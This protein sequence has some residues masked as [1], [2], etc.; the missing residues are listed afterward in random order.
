ML[1]AERTI[2]V[3]FKSVRTV[4]LVLCC[5]IVSS[6]S[7]YHKPEYFTS[8]ISQIQGP[9]SA[10]SPHLPVQPGWKQTA[11]APASGGKSPPPAPAPRGRSTA[12]AGQ[13]LRYASNYQ[14]SQVQTVFQAQCEI[15]K[16]LAEKSNCVIVGRC[17]DYA[18]RHNPDLKSIFIYAPIEKR[19]E[20]IMKRFDLTEDKAKSQI[21]KEDKEYF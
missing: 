5:I 18:L 17:A 2:L 9:S 7:V 11:H 10:V 14:L 20:T 15:L 3:H 13:S 6:Q 16:S 21:N 1:S 8:F 4:L 19:I 12:C